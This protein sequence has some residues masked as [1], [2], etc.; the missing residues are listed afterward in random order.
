MNQK[1]YIKQ[2]EAN[3][4]NLK[5]GNY[6]IEL[7]NSFSNLLKKRRWARTTRKLL[8]ICFLKLLIMIIQMYFI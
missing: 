1:Q 5:T 6:K 2:F 7:G 8:S 4:E 3:K